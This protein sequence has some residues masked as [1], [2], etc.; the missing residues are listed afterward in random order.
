MKR[1]VILNAFLIAGKP[2]CQ[3][4]QQIA[5]TKAAA[6]QMAIALASLNTRPAQSQVPM[7]T[8]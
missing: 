1:H 4:S 8:T 6:Q 5:A 3:T 7:Q 2:V